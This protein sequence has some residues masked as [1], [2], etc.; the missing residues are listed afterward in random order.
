LHKMKKRRFR[1]MQYKRRKDALRG[2]LST[3]YIHETCEHKS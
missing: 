3:M 2:L 1:Y